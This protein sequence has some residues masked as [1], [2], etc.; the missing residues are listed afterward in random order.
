MANLRLFLA[1]MLVVHLLLYPLSSQVVALDEGLSPTE[2][3][4]LELIGRYDSGAG[5]NQGGAE[6]VTFDRYTKQA[7][8]VNGAHHAI[9]IVDLSTIGD[10][11]L[12]LERKGRIQVSE[13]DLGAGFQ[14]GDITSVAIHPG[15]D[16]IA[17]S[18]PAERERI[19]G[20]SSLLIP[21]GK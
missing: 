5:F 17:F 9:D 12:Q 21:M 16:F 2:E 15:G 6:I 14:I 20:E 19:M 10:S 18:V 1:N 4:Q 8:I 13:L 7:F 11:N 3:I